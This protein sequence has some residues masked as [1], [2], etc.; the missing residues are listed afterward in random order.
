MNKTTSLGAALLLVGFLGAGAM[1]CGSEKDTRTPEWS[2]IS[3]T[4]VE[5]SCATANCHS[6]LRQ[7]SGVDLSDRKI[8][9]RQLV[10]RHFVIPTKPE[11]SALVQ[12][13]KG[14][15]SRRMPPDFAL[16]DDDIALIERWIADGAMWDG[17]GQAPAEFETGTAGN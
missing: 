2:Y 4:I 11:V 15:G 7:R 6:V 12:L 8:A 14:E 3:A 13:L 17:P 16:P 9:Y 5:P 10:G 1:G